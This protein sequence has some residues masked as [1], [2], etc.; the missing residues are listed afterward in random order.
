MNLPAVSD[1][2]ALSS[3][4]MTIRLCLIRIMEATPSV[5]IVWVT[6]RR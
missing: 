3:W 2:Q 5:L 1:H 6:A 4:S